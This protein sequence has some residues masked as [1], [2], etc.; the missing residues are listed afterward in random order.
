M[1]TIKYLCWQLRSWVSLELCHSWAAPGLGTLQ[2]GAAH[3][4]D[5]E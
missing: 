1:R 4:E 2:T 3:C 5:D